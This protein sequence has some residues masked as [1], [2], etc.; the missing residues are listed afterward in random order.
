MV[1]V[2]LV[3]SGICG[4]ECTLLSGE[5]IMLS[6]YCRQITGGHQNNQKKKLLRNK[7]RLNDETKIII[8]PRL[9]HD[10]GQRGYDNIDDETLAL[11][12]RSNS[13]S[14]SPSW[15]WGSS[16]QSIVNIAT[17]TWREEGKRGERPRVQRILKLEVTDNNAGLPANRCSATGRSLA[18]RYAAPPGGQSGS[19]F[20]DTNLD[21]ITQTERAMIGQGRES[22]APDH[23]RRRPS[24]CCW[25]VFLSRSLGLPDFAA[26]Y[27]G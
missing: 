21:W 18:A 1:V 6:H 26:G 7:P 25:Y 9:C 12:S 5:V 22:R 20:I 19:K 17:N 11:R 16:E 4:I 24:R 10:H 15:Y 27:Q 23:S 8:S 2:V 13:K 14:E 3:V